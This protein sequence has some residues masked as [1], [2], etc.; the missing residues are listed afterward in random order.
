MNKEYDKVKDQEE[1]SDKCIDLY[2]I[3]P[4]ETLKKPIIIF[5]IAEANRSYYKNF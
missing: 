2:A 5:N 1:N 4:E 3:F